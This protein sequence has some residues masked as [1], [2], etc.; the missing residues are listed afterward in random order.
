MLCRVYSPV[1]N[2]LQSVSC[3]GWPQTLFMQCIPKPIMSATGPQILRHAKIVL[4][5][6][7]QPSSIEVESLTK[8]LGTDGYVSD[9][10]KQMT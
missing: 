6:F 7:D 3:I 2:R 4:F 9:R 10:Q 8:A 1:T 5:E